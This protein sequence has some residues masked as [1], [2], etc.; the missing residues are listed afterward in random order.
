MLHDER[1]PLLQR[2]I[3][4][5]VYFGCIHPFPDSN[6]KVY[7]LLGD[8]FLLKQGIQPPYYAK[9]KRENEALVYGCQNAYFLDR[10]RDVSIFYPLLVEAYAG[11]GFVFQPTTLPAT[12]LPARSDVSFSLP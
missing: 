2:Y 5:I 10:Q 6:G 11:C 7:M 9:Y 1:I 4:F 3:R 12:D 8:L